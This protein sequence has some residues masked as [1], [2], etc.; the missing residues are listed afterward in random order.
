VKADNILEV[1][2]RLSKPCKNNWNRFL[3][4]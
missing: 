3:I 2:R 4:E 1:L